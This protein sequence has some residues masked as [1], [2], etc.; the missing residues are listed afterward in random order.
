[1]AEAWL[2]AAVILGVASI[3]YAGLSD[4]AR[5]LRRRA[6]TRL[7]HRD[8]APD[9]EGEDTLLG[10]FLFWLMDRPL[11]AD[12]FREMEA[13]LDATGKTPLQAR[14]YYLLLCLLLPL[15]VLVVTLVVLGFA[16]GVIAFVFAFYLSRRGIRVAGSM[17]EKQQN[18]E[19]VE[20]CYMTQMLMEAG[21]SPERTLRLISVQARELMPLLVRRIDRFNRVMD[22]G[23]ERSRALEELGSNRNLTV[24]RNYVSLMKQAGTMGTAVS[25]G[26]YAD[27]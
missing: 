23:A 11:L 17:A 4:P 21:L 19:A 18:R 1:M 16:P 13:S 12:D 15:A 8:L 9:V 27:Y 10:G 22:S 14:S 20:L 6:V 24:L 3:I 25:R 5:I 2:V 26:T 7:R